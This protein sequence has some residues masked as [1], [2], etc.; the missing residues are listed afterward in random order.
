MRAPHVT[1]LAVVLAVP[2]FTGCLA[3]DTTPAAQLPGGALQLPDGVIVHSPLGAV[4][5]GRVTEPIAAV[6]RLLGA[7]TFEPTLGVAPDGAIFYSIVKAGVAI[8]AEPGVLRSTDGG[9]T[10]TDVSPNLAGASMPPET[11]DPYLYVD[12]DT[13][14]V[15]QFAMAPILVCAVLSWSDD[16]GESWT[17]NPRGCGNTPPWDHQTIVA[18]NAAMTPLAPTYS[19]VVHQCVNQLAAAWCSRSLDGG[20]TFSP[21]TPAIV[22]PDCSGL[23]GHLVAHPSG[24]VFLPKDECGAS[25][26]LITRDDGLTWER[27]DVSAIPTQ[28][29]SDPAIAVDDA[30]N[31]YYAFLD[32]AGALML[33]MSTDVGATWSEPVVASPPGVTAHIPAIAAG[34][35]GRIILAYPGTTDLPE[36][37]ASSD[38]ENQAWHAYVTVTT[39]GLAL[40]NATFQTQ[41]VTPADDPLVRGACGPARCPG[42]TDFIDVVVGPD[43]TPY[44]SFVDTCIDACAS[45]PAAE[46]N[47]SAAVLVTLTGGPPLREAAG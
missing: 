12:P 44:A 46:N 9:L 10:W 13:G 20:L 14:R 8:G 2:V 32:A 33:S 25:I 21:G 45:D 42:M 39:D 28:A 16:G 4:D 30:G 27:V 19:K 36:G 23:H 41:R 22:S 40:G 34:A 31:V 38:V 15:F 35:E 17:T 37:Y 24:V 26:V 6:M 47:A 7:D 18:A 29:W 3:D 43:G 5:A 11:N 1:L